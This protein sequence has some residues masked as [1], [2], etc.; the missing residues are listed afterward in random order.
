MQVVMSIVKESK[1]SENH[2]Y[3]FSNVNPNVMTV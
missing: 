1:D 3:S 2:L